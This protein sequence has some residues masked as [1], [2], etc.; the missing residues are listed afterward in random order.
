MKWMDLFHNLVIPFLGGFTL[1]LAKL[2]A[3]QKL[4]SSKRF[5]AI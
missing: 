5:E 2:V 1:T 3:D 4:L